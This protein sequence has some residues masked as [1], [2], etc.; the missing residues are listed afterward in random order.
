MHQIFMGGT[1]VYRELL[2]EWRA[3][4]LQDDLEDHLPVGRAQASFGYLI[5]IGLSGEP[6]GPV[7]LIGCATSMHS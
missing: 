3:E 2:E 7:N 6:T 1:L 5:A 4:R